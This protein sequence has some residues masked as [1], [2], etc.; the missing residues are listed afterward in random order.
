MRDDKGLLH[1]VYVS[2]VLLLSIVIFILFV[3]LWKMRRRLGKFGE[4]QNK[5][6]E[7]K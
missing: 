5:L 3:V 2:V 1:G 7:T 4:M 6:L